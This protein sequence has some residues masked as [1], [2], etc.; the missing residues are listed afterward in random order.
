MSDTTTTG[1]VRP[2]YADEAGQDAETGYDDGRDARAGD[3]AGRT[4]PAFDG[5]ARDDGYAD[6]AFDTSSYAAP[7]DAEAY[8]DDEADDRAYDRADD[9]ARGYDHDDARGYQ[10][11]ATDDA[12][13][14]PPRGRR[15]RIHYDPSS[16]RGDNVFRDATRHSRFVRLLRFVLPALAVVGTLV[17]V[18]AVRFVPG[19]FDD[20]VS[21]AGI[22]VESNSVVMNSPQI[23]GFEGT[24]RAYLVKAASAIQSLSDPKVLTFNGIDASLGLDDAGTVTVTAAKGIYDGNTNLLSLPE[25]ASVTTTEG[26]SARMTDAEID[27]EAGSLTSDQPLEIGMVGG[28]LRANGIRVADQGKRIRFINGVSLRYV[29][30][31]DLMAPGTGETGP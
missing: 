4:A 30:R 26:Y 2:R 9:D 22:D 16:A 18:A 6:G 17:F 15:R 13:L 23:S 7:A 19:S 10:A 3:R 12:P 24:R 29:P 20:L 28:T 27:L 5:Y 14:P 8:A 21:V 1:N 11:P 25:G 31:D